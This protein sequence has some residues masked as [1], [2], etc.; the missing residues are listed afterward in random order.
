VPH[1]RL[2][3][4]RDDPGRR[5]HSDAA[6]LTADPITAEQAFEHGL[7][8]RLAEPGEAVDVA[9]ALAE[10][11]ARNA[12]RAVAASKWLIRA[13]PGCTEEDFWAMQLPQIPGV[14][15]SDDAREGPRAFAEKRAPVWS[16]R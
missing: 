7:V 13:S 10:R 1:Q 16:G 6:P 4:R 3:E 11:I 12:P 15:E 9:L 8:T 14:F 5:R 2:H